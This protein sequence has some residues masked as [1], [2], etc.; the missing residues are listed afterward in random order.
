MRITQTD[1]GKVFGF[2]YGELEEGDTF[3]TA[4]INHPCMKTDE[5]GDETNEV[6]FVSL[7]SGVAYE[8]SDSCSVTPIDCE[9]KWSVK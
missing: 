2:T 5:R 4:E 8:L 1:T 3:V 6:L 9:L 7:R